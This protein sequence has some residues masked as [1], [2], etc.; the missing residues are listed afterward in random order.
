MITIPKFTKE[1]KKDNLRLAVKALR[2]NPKKAT[3]QMM[4]DDGG[5]CC[6]CV[7][8]HVAE[9]I[10]GAERNS[11]CAFL[12]TKINLAHV[13]A[14]NVD[15]SHDVLLWDDLAS[16]WNDGDSFLQEKTHAEIADMLEKEYL[17]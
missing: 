17:A 12:D 5:R 6:L 13:F 1:Q 10:C 7:M 16:N 4:D 14:V 2:E 8:A 11:F 3:K 15:D 9:D